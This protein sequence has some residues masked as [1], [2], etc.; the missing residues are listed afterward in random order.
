MFIYF[1][2]FP[3]RPY[4]H[5]LPDRT[6]FPPSPHGKRACQPLLPS[7]TNRP[8]SFARDSHPL[9][10]NDTMSKSFTIAEVAQHKDEKEGMYI[11][12]DGAVYDVASTS[13][14]CF[15]ILWSCYVG[16]VF[17][18]PAG[19]CSSMFECLVFL[20]CHDDVFFSS[21]FYMDFFCHR[22]F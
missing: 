22:W 18:L 6:L 21:C 17:V 5:L 14:F 13:H 4:L 10:Q 12:I 7:I 8:V 2:V 1:L 11:V 19:V 15:S 16:I 3:L 9:Q 20:S